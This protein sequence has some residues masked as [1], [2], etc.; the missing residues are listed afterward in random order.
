MPAFSAYT[1]AKHALRG[2]LNALQIEEREQ[3]TGVRVAMVSPGPI[4]TPIYERATSGTGRRPAILPAYT[5]ET[6]AAALVEAALAPR[7]DRI[8]G[9]VSKLVDL[10]YRRCAACG[11]AAAA[12]RRSL[13]PD[14][15]DPIRIARSPVGAGWSAAGLRR[16]AVPRPRRPDRAGTP[17]RPARRRG[18]SARHPRS[19]ARC[20]SIGATMPAASR[21]LG[22]LPLRVQLLDR[23]LHARRRLRGAGLPGD[24][25]RDGAAQRL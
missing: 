16:D 8:V 15:H 22:L 13:V 19:C 9:G 18:P 23:R 21:A 14:R 2:F 20:R 4:D 10:L 1:A 24:G 7:H 5:P 12:V 11:R 25:V 3:R 6:V 17:P